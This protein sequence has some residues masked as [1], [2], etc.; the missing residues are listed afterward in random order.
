LNQSEAAEKLE[1]S[2]SFL[3]EIESGKKSPTLE[4]LDRYAKAFDIPASTFLLFSEQSREPKSTGK[5]KPPRK[6]LQ[7]LEWASQG[8]EEEANGKARAAK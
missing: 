2:N 8:V 6:I 5:Q 1:I 4:L 7:F 3:C